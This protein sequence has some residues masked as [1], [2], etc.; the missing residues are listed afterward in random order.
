MPLVNASMPD[1]Q[2]PL[3]QNIAI[4]SNNV[5]SRIQKSK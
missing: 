5:H 1:V 4:M 3:S 2:Q